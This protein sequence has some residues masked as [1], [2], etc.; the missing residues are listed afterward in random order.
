MTEIEELNNG[1]WIVAGDTHLG[2]WAKEHGSII[3]DPYLFKFLK[4]FLD[5]AQIVWDIGANIGNHSRQYLDWG[6]TVIAIEPNPIVFKCLQHN[7][8]EAAC[9]N[10]A[11]SDTNGKLKFEQ[12]DNVGASRIGNNGDILVSAKSLDKVKNLP[13]PDFVKIDVEGWEVKALLGM[14][15]TLKKYKPIIYI[16]VN[17]EALINNGYK[18]DDIL[19][20]LQDTLNYSNLIKYPE[21]ANFGD[22]QYDILALPK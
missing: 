10:I 17:S 2:L 11:A 7:C 18:E 12:L 13:A 3:T 9:L 8:P 20:I 1:Q 4:P 16:E 22:P 14:I 19:H 15:K 6:K 5:E 21:T